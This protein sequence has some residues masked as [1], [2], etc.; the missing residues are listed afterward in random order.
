MFRGESVLR[1]RNGYLCLVS[2]GGWVRRRWRSV[3]WF[4]FLE[5]FGDFGKKRLGG[6]VG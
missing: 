6:V 1:R 2:L 4:W 3:I 5:F